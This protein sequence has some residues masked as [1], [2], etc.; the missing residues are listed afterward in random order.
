MFN[1]ED[2]E[3]HMLYSRR[4]KTYLLELE[5]DCHEVVRDWDRTRELPFTVLFTHF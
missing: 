3:E 2:T 1:K 5:S 4:G